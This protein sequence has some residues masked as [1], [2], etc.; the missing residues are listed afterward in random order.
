MDLL[1]NPILIGSWFWGISMMLGAIY[2]PFLNKLLKTVPLNFFDLIL[3]LT[4]GI[5]NLVLIEA[6][7]WYF[8]TKRKK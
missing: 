5:L 7:K 2:L 6:T 4:I 3:V 1:S 8:I